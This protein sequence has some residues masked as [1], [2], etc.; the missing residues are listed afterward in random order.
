MVYR[1]SK[2]MVKHEQQPL[3]PAEYPQITYLWTSV[4]FVKN[5]SPWTFLN[6][7]TMRFS[8]ATHLLIILPHSFGS[9]EC[10]TQPATWKDI[11]EILFAAR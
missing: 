7:E 1:Q 2:D 9:I 5:N 4:S 10:V 8:G 6:T 3:S 11:S